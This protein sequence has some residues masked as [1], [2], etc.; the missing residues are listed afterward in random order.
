MKK[1]YTL[2]ARLLDEGYENV[3]DFVRRSGCPI[4]PE[5]IRLAVYEGKQVSTPSLMLVMKYL[6]YAPGE[7]REYLED[8]GEHEFSPL[9]PTGPSSALAPWETS[10]LAVARKVRDD[11]PA[12]WN[13]LIVQL[14]LMLK[15]DLSKLEMRTTNNKK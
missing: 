1:K 10:F 5:T 14:G 6:N 2:K 9:L 3:T 13:S 4:S 7:I 8:S 12:L 11:E 15:E